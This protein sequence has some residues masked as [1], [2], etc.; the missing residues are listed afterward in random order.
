MTVIEPSP[1]N[2]TFLLKL[3]SNL[4]TRLDGDGHVVTVDDRTDSSGGSGQDDVTR[5]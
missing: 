5:Q 1:P 3:R 2:G 4:T